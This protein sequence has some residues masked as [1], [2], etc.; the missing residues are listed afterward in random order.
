MVRS[1]TELFPNG[2][3]MFRAPAVALGLFFHLYKNSTLKIS[4]IHSTIKSVNLP[5]YHNI[6]IGNTSDEKDKILALK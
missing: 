1:F 4:R 3:L 6:F 2:A 5:P